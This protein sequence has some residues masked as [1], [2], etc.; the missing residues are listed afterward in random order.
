VSDAEPE[1]LIY[2]GINPELG[3]IPEPEP[4]IER[5]IPSLA[6]LIG[7]KTLRTNIRRAKWRSILLEI[8]RLA[9]ECPIV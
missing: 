7:Y 9:M 4:H 8:G 6:G 1:A 3:T 2:L 5:G